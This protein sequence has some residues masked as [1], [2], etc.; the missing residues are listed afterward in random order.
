MEKPFKLYII[1]ISA[2]LSAFIGFVIFQNKS[3]TTQQL[4]SR[5][6]ANLQQKE[7]IAKT[8]LDLLSESLK[9]I[10]PKDL[11]VSYQGTIN[12]LYKN[13]GVAIYVYSHDSLCFWT[14][15]QPAVD[16]NAYTNET[17][18]Q[19]I[20]I[21]NGYY[22]YIKQKDS[23]KNDYTV[24]AL[25]SIK[26]EFDFE[27]RYLN[28]NFSDWLRLPEGSRLVTPVNFLKHAVKSK[29]GPPLFEVYRSEGLHIS[30]TYIAYACFFYGISFLLFLA[31]L[32]LFLKRNFKKEC[33]FIS[34]FGLCCVIIRTLMI[35]FKIPTVFYFS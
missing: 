9:K 20:K 26:P 3:L 2:L 12:D 18:V 27:N 1:F 10:K 31:L 11:F 33:L 8:N 21:R 7:A 5:A 14:D 32:F 13:D 23:L 24:V 16:L 15:N 4:T 28:N 30:S 35:W 29:F 6:E 34:V 22:E 19:L 25:I 17:N